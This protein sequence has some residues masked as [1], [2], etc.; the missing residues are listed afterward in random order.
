MFSRSELASAVLVCAV[1]VVVTPVGNKTSI[2][3]VGFLAGLAAVRSPTYSEAILRSARAGALGGLLF[4]T[5]MGLI[6]AGRVA[7]VIGPL[8]AVDKF[9]FTSFAMFAMV[10][11][12]YGIEGVVVGPAVHWIEEKASK[13]FAGSPSAPRRES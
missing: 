4:I 10:V 2:I 9:L 13:A 8:Y 3:P 5:A 1:A 12:M 11:P 7:S 6:V